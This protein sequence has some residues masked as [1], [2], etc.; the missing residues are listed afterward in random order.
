MSLIRLNQLNKIYRTGS[1]VTVKALQNVSLSIE[2]GE[3]VAIM[4]P[5]GSGKS[6]LLAVLGLLDKA[7][8]GEYFLL[9]KN[10]SQLSEVQYAKLRNRFFGF[11]FQT[12]NLL[13]KLNLLDNVLLPFIY[14]D[15]V[16]EEKRKAVDV[17]LRKVGL[18]DRLK[19]K[20]NQLSG[21][22]QQRAAL[23]R[24]LSNKPLV[25]L[26]DEPTGNL[27]SK[28]S[29]EIMAV[30]K[31]LNEQG[32]TIIMVTHEHD[33]ATWASR[34]L[35]L[36]DGQIIKDE[37]KRK[38][39]T[40]ADPAPATQEKKQSFWSHLGNLKNYFYEAFLS[41]V[42]NKLRS[43]LSILG[44]TIGVAAVIAMLALGTGA[45]RNME[46]RLAGLGTNVL[47]VRMQHRS[48][49]ISMGSGVGTRFSF[50]DLEVLKKI[51]GVAAVAPYVTGNVQA[52]FKNNNWST[53]V[54]GTDIEYQK[55]KDVTPALGR[56]FTRA[57]ANGRAK[58]CVLG[59]TVADELF[60][61]NNPV[62]QSVRLNRVSFTVVGVMPEQGSFGWRNYDNQ[63]LLPIKTAMYR[64]LGNNY[65][66]YFEV[67]VRDDEMMQNVQDEI[68][69]ELL[70]LHRL[71]EADSE[72]FN[73]I[74]TAQIQEA[75]NAMMATLTFLLGSIAM[76]SLLVGGIGIMNI[77]LVTVVERTHE[78]GLR[79]ALGAQKSDIMLQFLVESIIICLFGGV[80]GIVLGAAI[81]W[82]FSTIAGWVIYISLASV[83]LAFTFSVVVGVVFGLWP[84]NRAAKLL[85][86][87]AL[88][89]E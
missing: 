66:S 59:K 5:S 75:A 6:T 3:F 89:Y 67:K 38:I 55:I 40:L 10:I 7:D 57:E 83:I 43:V 14:A 11:V 80:V 35:S 9:E 45:Q 76:V 19:H 21:G 64:L 36:H 4:G 25:I 44:V 32:H 1:E 50:A 33:I 81:S 71:S 39:K 65:I 27:D 22:Q 84:A 72:I 70:R 16:D 63:I 23:V 69:L 60:A 56:Y 30:F 52:V 77:M 12:F 41:V 54:V 85:P 68:V 28:S 58:V 20:P 42:N 37:K 34:V 15:E 26:A 86:V 62:G 17:T 31:E 74:N 48:R 49:G 88:R 82:A 79:K 53:N 61:E 47:M 46:E 78:I 2:R 87:E 8:S 13:P 18:H 51:E 29:Q 24:A 73:I